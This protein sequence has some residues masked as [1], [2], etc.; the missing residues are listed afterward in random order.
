MNQTVIDLIRHG[1]PQG[2]SL[3]RGHSI[4]DPLSAKGWDQMWHAVGSYK[5][6]QQIVSSPL[7]R[8]NAF[9]KRL[10]EKNS[11]PI[12]IE[13]DLKEIGFGSWEGLSREQVKQRN[14]EEY[15]QFY[16]DPVNNRPAGAEDLNA[17][18][19]RVTSC[20]A[21][22]IQQFKGQH[23][24]IVAHAGVIRAILAHIVSAP[25]NGLYNFRIANAGISRLHVESNEI[26]FINK[27]FTED[28]L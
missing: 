16:A 1:E 5:Q 18:I 6:W 27:E 28:N 10:A 2:G 19:Q 22:L 20:Y 12:Y 26:V 17:F 4:D 3:Y 24:L 14:L 25:P 23:V 8:C 13:D 15:N 11:I 21:K 7:S 9:A